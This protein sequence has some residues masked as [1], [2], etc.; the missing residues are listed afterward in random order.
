MRNLLIILF[1]FSFGI[2]VLGIEETSSVDL[3][4][5]VKTY[6]AAHLDKSWEVFTFSDFPEVQANV[7]WYKED[8]NAIIAI[9]QTVFEN[10][11]QQWV[12]FRDMDAYFDTVFQYYLPYNLQTICAST[13]IVQRNFT[14]VNAGSDF[15]IKHYFQQLDIHQIRAIGLYFP[16]QFE[17]ELN[18]TAALF[19]PDFVGCPED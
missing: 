6:G 13:L 12:Y 19:Y 18:E 17:A 4:R 5:E 15:L 11:I 2:P 7:Y 8:L 14:A 10:P 9:N 16:A 3:L 1:L